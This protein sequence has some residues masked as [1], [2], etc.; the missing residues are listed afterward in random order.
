MS[1]AVGSHQKEWNRKAVLNPHTNFG[2][3]NDNCESVGD[4]KQ[5]SLTIFARNKM[6]SFPGLCRLS[7]SKVDLTKD[8]SRQQSNHYH[9]NQ[10][11]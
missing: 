6:S 7:P 11:Q 10:K 5:A 4:E 3:L 1:V 2:F 9:G 8:H